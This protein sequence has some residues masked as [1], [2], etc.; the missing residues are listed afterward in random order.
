MNR[1][2]KAKLQD[3]KHKSRGSNKALIPATPPELSTGFEIDLHNLIHENEREQIQ[4]VDSV[5]T[6][7]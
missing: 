5:S 2:A 1:R 3:G 4:I 6:P 7:F